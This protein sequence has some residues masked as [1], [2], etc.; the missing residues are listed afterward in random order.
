[1]LKEARGDGSPC[2]QAEGTPSS[3]SPAC[4]STPGTAQASMGP[5]GL[6]AAARPTNLSPVI[7]GDC[8][9]NVGRGDVG[10]VGV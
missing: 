10:R 4:A 3:L 8:R 2:T 1:M 7:P 5:N 9:G 6:P